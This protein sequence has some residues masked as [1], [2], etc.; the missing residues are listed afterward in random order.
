MSEYRRPMSHRRL[1]IETVHCQE[2]L[3]QGNHKPRDPD[4][5][6]DEQPRQEGDAPQ[7]RMLD[8][9]HPSLREI[10]KL[11]EQLRDRVRDATLRQDLWRI[12]QHA[13]RLNNC[14][15]EQSKTVQ[16]QHDTFVRDQVELA[17]LMDEL[18]KRR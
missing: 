18:Q 13:V 10:C 11:V 14:L 17:T 5:F 1:E 16:E 6:A 4:P 2:M 12:E 3:R 8:A 7:A 15:V 9:V